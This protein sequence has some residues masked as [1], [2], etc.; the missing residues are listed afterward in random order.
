MA[1]IKLGSD[2]RVARYVSHLGQIRDDDGNCLGLL[3]SAFDLRKEKGET[4]LSINCVDRAHTTL[5]AALKLIRG[6]LASKNLK[7]RHAVL[8]LGRAGEIRATLGSGKVTLTSEPTKIDPSYGA[9]RNLPLER[10]A[11]L[12]RLATATW[13]DWRYLRDC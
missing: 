4:Y 10:R 9:I 12:E 2:E 7:S 8:A 3:W 6:F 1:R 11:A 5:G 13:A